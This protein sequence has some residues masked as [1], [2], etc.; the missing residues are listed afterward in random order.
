MDILAIYLFGSMAT[1]K[2]IHGHSDYDFGVIFKNQPLAPEKFMDVYSPIYD[3]LADKLPRAYLKKR[4]K[5]GGHDFDVVFL[6]EGPIRFQA[7]AIQ[8]GKVL[9]QSDKERLAVYREHVLEQFCDLQY[10]YAIS[11]ENLMARL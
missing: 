8:E 4:Q 5:I 9:Y 10:I 11:H 3:M 7:K 2:Y 6:Q 1:E